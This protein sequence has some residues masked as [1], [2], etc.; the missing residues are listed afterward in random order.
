VDHPEHVAV[1]VVAVTEDVA[2]A[3]ADRADP[4]VRVAPETRVDE[5]AASAAEA[6]VPGAI[7]HR[8]EKIQASKSA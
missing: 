1:A 8:K 5:A 6:V 2:A 3:V 4:V 7:G